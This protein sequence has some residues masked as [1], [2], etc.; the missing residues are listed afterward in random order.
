[1]LVPVA[2]VRFETLNDEAFRTKKLAV[3][4]LLIE[5]APASPCV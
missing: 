1:M 2:M 4:G 5:E 3:Y